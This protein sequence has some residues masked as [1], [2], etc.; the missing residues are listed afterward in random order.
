MRV[1]TLSTHLR[2]GSELVGWYRDATSVPYGHLLIDLSPRTDDRLRYCTNTGSIHSKFYISDR[3]KQS[4]FFDDEHTKS[5]FCQSVPILLPQM[6]KSSPAVL[7]KRAYQVPL[8]AYSRSFQ[9]NPAK[10]GKTS[11]DKISKRCSIALSEQNHL[12]AKNRRSGIQKRVITQ[13]RYYPSRH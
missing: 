1:S 5:L 10:H 6:Q 13:K 12:E 9:R 4:E 8:R 11:R 3:R 7:A 2:L